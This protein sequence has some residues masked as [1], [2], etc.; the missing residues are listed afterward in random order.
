MSERAHTPT[1]WRVD[2]EN[3][4]VDMHDRVIVPCV[5]AHDVPNPAFTPNSKQLISKDDGGVQNAEFI[6]RAVNG[7]DKLLDRLDNIER[8]CEGLLSIIETS[9]PARIHSGRVAN[10]RHILLNDPIL[11]ASQNGGAA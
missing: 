1:P 10:A 8:I 2:D 3:K 11:R 5:Q 7:F 6:C 4:I 9:D